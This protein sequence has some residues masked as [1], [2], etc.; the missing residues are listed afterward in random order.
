MAALSMRLRVES[1]RAHLYGVYL[2]TFVLHNT[3]QNLNEIYIYFNQKVIFFPGSNLN[4]LCMKNKLEIGV[5]V[6]EIHKLVNWKQR[7]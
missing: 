6:I 4:V 1:D 7:N 3:V 5:T 2:S